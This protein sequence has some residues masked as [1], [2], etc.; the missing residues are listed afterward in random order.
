[1]PLQ[2]Q[3][4]NLV[5][6]QGIDTKTNQK[7]VEGKLLEMENCEINNQEVVKSPG[8]VSLAD[9][10]TSLSDPRDQKGLITEL[11]TP[12]VAD[13]N[14]LYKYNSDQ[15]VL[16]KVDNIIFASVQQYAIGQ[17]IS[18]AVQTSPVIAGAAKNVNQLY[19]PSA[20]LG[21]PTPTNFNIPQPISC[22][23]GVYLFTISFRVT[24]QEISPLVGFQ[25]FY[26]IILTNTTNQAALY[27]STFPQSDEIPQDAVATPNGI[28]FYTLN[29]NS[30]NVNE[31]Y[32]SYDL[33][34][35]RTS[36]GLP[37][38]SDIFNPVNVMSIN[39]TTIPNLTAYVNFL[40]VEYSS[41]FIF[42][43]FR[44][45]TTA[46]Y[47]GY[48]AVRDLGGGSSLAPTSFTGAL[49]F[50]TSQESQT[51]CTMIFYHPDTETKYFV[52]AYGTAGS[53]QFRIIDVGTR[54]IRSSF[55]NATTTGYSTHS[56]GFLEKQLQL[57][58]L[59]HDIR[60]FDGTS[61]AK[62]QIAPLVNTY[63]LTQTS[64]GS[65]NLTSTAD[66]TGVVDDPRWIQMYGTSA[67][68]GRVICVYDKIVFPIFYFC[69]L[70]DVDG[71]T[72]YSTPIQ[73]RHSSAHLV[74]FIPVIDFPGP[75]A[76]MTRT[77]S[78][79]SWIKEFS[80]SLFTPLT[81][82]AVSPI[83]NG[84]VS[85]PPTIMRSKVTFDT[86]NEQ[87]NNLFYGFFIEF[88]FVSQTGTISYEHKL[89]AYH[90]GIPDIFNFEGYTRSSVYFGSGKVNELTQS[91]I[92][93]MNFFDFPQIAIGAIGAAGSITAGKYEYGAHYEWTN[94]NGELV[95]SDVSRVEYT[96]GTATTSINVFVTPPP[97]FSNKVE[98][99]MRIFRSTVNGSELFFDNNLP[100]TTTAPMLIDTKLDTDIRN[101]QFIYTTGGILG[102]FPFFAVRS[103][104]LFRNCIFA[105]DA[106][107]D[108]KIWYSKSQT[109]G[110]AMA[111]TDSFYFYVD[112]RGGRS[113]FLMNM[114]DK[115]LIFKE[116]SVFEVEG[117]VPDDLGENSTLTT[118]QFIT[119]PVGCSEPNSAVVFPDG[120]IFKSKKGLW[121]LDR[122]L[123]AS[124]IG[125][126]VELYNNL[127]ITSAKL[128]TAVNKVKFS[129]IEGINLVYDY[130]YKTW[131][132][133]RMIEGIEDL[134]I[135]DDRLTMI[136]SS[137]KILQENNTIFLRDGK[138]YTMR[139]TTGWVK[140]TGLSGFQ[141]LYKIMFLGN[142]TGSH[143]LKASVYFN[144]NDEPSEFHYFNPTQNLG[145][146][147]A[148]LDQL[149]NPPS[150]YP[151]NN[152]SWGQVTPYAGYQD[153]TYL[154]RIN[155]RQQKCV[156]VKITLEDVFTGLSDQ[157]GSSFKA[158]NLNFD[159]GA[160]STTT[161]VPSRLAV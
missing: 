92:S 77:L 129:T 11:N 30:G 29:V 79:V 39:R 4:V 45:G 57:V 153:S 146:A 6:Y 63:T 18:E 52:A 66:L 136:T 156:S 94:G 62:N 158:T 69:Y 102:D 144:Y 42:F 126:D 124:Y 82:T 67:I 60:E 142:Y 31:Y 100:I 16:N 27:T 80:C 86:E 157:T 40:S 28:F 84:N 12:V 9:D 14:S 161:K 37:F 122:S 154:F 1:M 74:Q 15:N 123:N 35:I 107:E 43:A 87:A 88:A 145:I 93:E 131:N 121:Q 104:T 117:D 119:S 13:N 17:N 110:V 33:S 3:S 116:D 137:G 85:V 47:Q 68:A 36:P 125:A 112:S 19:Y 81:T 95:R 97:F 54:L 133:E 128:L 10:Q 99:V 7:L 101:N 139:F 134:T 143:I 58:Q 83:V 105:I 127:S 118:P 56:L 159:V 20:T 114:D 149:V 21:L 65:Y 103:F 41:G 38:S 5:L 22:Q 155:V 71:A 48:I 32:L 50:T 106:N 49:T 44:V 53:T 130:Y 8:S 25:G 61:I 64:P 151:F 98:T 120:V 141:R 111:T 89:N 147:N 78:H 90:L 115:L 26:D 132:I 160:K 34:L 55:A 113:Q 150:N 23:F 138:D 75:L 91:T 148:F 2:R 24:N 46:A 109:Q 73:L 59:I 96:L 70:L 108:N 76:G 51:L 140:L 72:A 135:V 152:V